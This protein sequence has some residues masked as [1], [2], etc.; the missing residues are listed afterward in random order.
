MIGN[1]TVRRRV[2]HVTVGERMQ[3]S[4][5]R[6]KPLGA[7]RQREGQP[8]AWALFQRVAMRD[9]SIL[10]DAQLVSSETDGDRRLSSPPRISAKVMT[11]ID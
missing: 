2:C 6:Y 3:L 4:A 11:A 9:I 1:E 7:S 5:R 8:Q 10:Q